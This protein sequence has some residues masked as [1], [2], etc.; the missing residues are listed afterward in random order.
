MN[1]INLE[2]IQKFI[3]EAKEDP[4]LFIK[5]KKVIGKWN[6]KEGEAQFFAEIEYPKGKSKI[7]SDLAPFM[8]GQGLKPD[9]IQYCLF[10]IASCFAGTFATIAAREMVEIEEMNIAAENQVDL[11][12]PMGVSNNPIVRS[13]KITV[14]INSR[15]SKNKLQEILQ[16]AMEKCPGIYCVSNA[17][18]ITAELNIKS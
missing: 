9:P 15:A 3:E 7:E 10:G 4:Q 8:G 6:L 16:E 18:P 13:V 11:S 1:K 17:I 2:A 12:K 14:E 5:T